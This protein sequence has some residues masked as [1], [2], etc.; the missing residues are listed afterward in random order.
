VN[1]R[2]TFG[3]VRVGGAALGGQGARVRAAGLAAVAGG[4]VKRRILHDQRQQRVVLFARVQVEHQAMAVIAHW[5]ERKHLGIDRG[6]EFDHHAHHAR[7]ILPGADQADIGI[8]IE[9]LRGQHLQHGIEFDAFEIDH[10]P[11]R[12]LDQQV[13]KP[14]RLVVLQRHPRVVR[15]RPDTHG[16]DAADRRG[17]G[18]DFRDQQRQAGCGKPEDITP[19]RHVRPSH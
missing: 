3:S 4:G 14:D 10:Q 15:R 5:R 18:A 2:F 16:E 11:L 1:S 13:G 6:L 7:A 9:D 12:I 17:A 8:R 19:A